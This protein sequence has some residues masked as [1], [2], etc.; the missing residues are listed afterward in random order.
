TDDENLPQGLWGYHFRDRDDNLIII[1]RSEYQDEA[2]YHEAREAAWINELQRRAGPNLSKEEIFHQAHILASAEQSLQFAIRD[3]AGNIIQPTPLHQEMI[4]QM[5]P[6]QLQQI[7]DENRT[8][9]YDLIREH[10]GEKAVE[11]QKEYEGVVRGEVENSTGPIRKDNDEVNDNDQEKNNIKH[12]ILHSLLSPASGNPEKDCKSKYTSQDIENQKISIHNFISAIVVTFA[13]IVRKVNVIAIPPR[14][15]N[16]KIPPEASR[17]NA[18]T[19]NEANRIFAPSR[20]KFETIFSSSLFNIQDYF[21]SLQN[22]VKGFFISNSLSNKESTVILIPPLLKNTLLQNPFFVNEIPEITLPSNDLF[23]SLGIRSEKNR[24]E[25]HNLIRGEYL[26][27]EE[28]KEQKEYEGVVKGEAMYP[29]HK[30]NELADALDDIAQSK[31]LVQKF[32]LMQKWIKS[33]LKTF[34]FPPRGQMKKPTIPPT[35]INTAID[36]LNKKLKLIKNALAKPAAIMIFSIS[37]IVLANKSLLFS[38]NINAFISIISFSAIIIPLLAGFV[39]DKDISASELQAVID[40]NRTEHHN[41]IREYFGENGFKEQEELPL[42]LLDLFREAGQ[43]WDTATEMYGDGLWWVHRQKVKQEIRKAVEL[44]GKDK[45]LIL[46]AGSNEPY[47]RRLAEKFNEITLNNLDVDSLKRAKESLPEDLQNKVRLNVED[48]SLVTVKLAREIENIVNTSSSIKEAL[49]RTIDLI[50]G[51]EPQGRLSFSDEEFDL[52]ISTMVI[53]QFIPFIRSFIARAMNEKFGY[54]LF[55]IVNNNLIHDLDDSLFDLSERILKKHFEELF[56]ILKPA[57]VICLSSDVEDLS[58]NS[59]LP[60]DEIEKFLLPDMKIVNKK[61][62]VWKEYPDNQRLV[63]SV[64]AKKDESPSSIK[65]FL[66]K[67][68]FAVVLPTLLIPIFFIGTPSGSAAVNSIISP[69]RISN[70]LSEEEMETLLK[71]RNFEATNHPG[72]LAKMKLNGFIDISDYFVREEV[73]KKFPKL[74]HFIIHGSSAP[75]C[76]YNRYGWQVIR[77][78]AENEFAKIKEIKWSDENNL[79]KHY[80]K[81]YGEIIGGDAKGYEPTIGDLRGYEY[82]C[83]QIIESRDTKIFFDL[84]ENKFAF[85]SKERKVR[86]SVGKEGEISTAFREEIRDFRNYWTPL[87]IPDKSRPKF[88][89]LFSSLT[90]IKE[91]IERDGP[92]SLRNLTRAEIKSSLKVKQI[93]QDIEDFCQFASKEEVEQLKE[94]VKNTSFK[95]NKIKRQIIAAIKP[96]SLTEPKI[97]ERGKFLSTLL[98]LVALPIKFNSSNDKGDNN[99][100]KIRQKAEELTEG[101]KT[102]REK[103]DKLCEF[104]RGIPYLLDPFWAR[105]PEEVLSQNEG[106]CVGKNWLLGEMH[107]EL[108][109]SV[110]YIVKEIKPER[111]FWNWIFWYYRNIRQQDFTIKLPPT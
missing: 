35:T 82:I 109:F 38:V 71:I 10:L 19:T 48:L 78:F 2:A 37:I 34:Y 57:G 111:E 62:W 36:N 97:T 30:F 96:P 66:K 21:N 94:F 13:A 65:S 60:S 108:G 42:P 59:I 91:K 16:Q 12:N 73:F 53:S 85:Y 27:E 107:K 79:R 77:K 93:F 54:G 110:R 99:I 88:R 68:I 63:Q 90:E 26:G 18:P 23:K 31:T 80:K 4:K 83:K 43:I 56:R 86:I 24:T 11:E 84:R 52:I 67:S 69:K 44:A 76:P 40:E 6:D 5:T 9:H 101:A 47:L 55:R 1:T 49:K 32:L 51:T 102:E 8:E 103:S 72:T 50:V 75:L 98:L 15:V 22:F 58:G 105:G 81:H 17:I 41:L 74:K 100:S 89:S 7:I 92:E 14:R 104:V 70:D 25:Q 61:E 20:K 95:D 3:K 87:N 64:I 29:F 45:V 39:K 106:M 46:G 28:L 33:Q